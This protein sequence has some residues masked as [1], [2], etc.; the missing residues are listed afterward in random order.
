[1][2]GYMNNNMFSGGPI[3]NDNNLSAPLNTQLEEQSYIE[4]ILRIN[5]GKKATFYMSYPDSV[6]W[7]DQVVTGT[8][9]AAGRDHIII[10]DDNS[11]KRF[12]LLMIYLNYVMFDEIIS[13]EYKR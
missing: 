1:M 6:E 8:I 7:R 3:P 13:Y 4:N 10:Q 9:K 12:L 2:N 5:K 11:N